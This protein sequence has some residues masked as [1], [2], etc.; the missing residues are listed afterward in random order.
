M[1][2]PHRPVAALPPGNHTHQAQ[3]CQQHGVGLWLR[4]G[5][6]VQQLVDKTQA[7]GIVAATDYKATDYLKA[8]RLRRVIQEAMG[9]VFADVDVLISPSRGGVA[10]RI[11]E[12]LD[13]GGRGRLPLGA[14]GNVAGLPALS[15]PCG[16][17]QNLPVGISVV[18]RAYQENLL[19]AV[20][21]QF[22]AQTDWHKRRPP[23]PA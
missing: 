19:L 5:L 17:A 7:A 16:L 18:S 23:L 21:K 15:L 8:M 20:G 22:Q 6:Y 12:R 11:S 1:G 3:T 4:H 9:K 10:E 14:A 13:V 2:A